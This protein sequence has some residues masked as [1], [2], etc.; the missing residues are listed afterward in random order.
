MAS[1]YRALEVDGAVIFLCGWHSLQRGAG[2]AGLVRAGLFSKPC[3]A[4]PVWRALY[5]RTWAYALLRRRRG[6]VVLDPCRGKVDPDIIAVDACF[7]ALFGE[8]LV[9]LGDA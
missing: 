7:A 2:T 1:W 8:S 9:N 6:L 4:G 5:V 3:M